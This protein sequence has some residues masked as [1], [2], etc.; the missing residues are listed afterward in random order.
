[1]NEVL[2]GKELTLDSLV[3]GN[4]KGK[5]LDPSVLNHDFHRIVKRDILNNVPLLRYTFEP[6]LQA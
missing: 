4:P 6:N 5:L 1:M 2:L 3:F